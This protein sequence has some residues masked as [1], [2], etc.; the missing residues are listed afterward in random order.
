MTE[1]LSSSISVRCLRLNLPKAGRYHVI[2][3]FLSRPFTNTL[4]ALHDSDHLTADLEFLPLFNGTHLDIATSKDSLVLYACHSALEEIQLIDVPANFRTYSYGN[5]FGRIHKRY[6]P[7]GNLLRIRR[8]GN[9]ILTIIRRKTEQQSQLRAIWN[10]IVEESLAARTVRHSV[11]ERFSQQWRKCLL[12]AVATESEILAALKLRHSVDEII[13]VIL[14]GKITEIERGI[15]PGEIKVTFAQ[16]KNDVYFSLLKACDSGLLSDFEFVGLCFQHEDSGRARPNEAEHLSDPSE[17]ECEALFGSKKNV[18]AII[19]VFES[20]KTVAMIESPLRSMFCQSFAARLAL[21]PEQLDWKPGSVWFR[22]KSL[23]AILPSASA[24]IED[25]LPQ[26]DVRPH[27]RSFVDQ[28]LGVAGFTTATKLWADLRD[29]EPAD[30]AGFRVLRPLKNPGAKKV[31]LFAC[32]AA[33]GELRPH[34]FHF[35]RELRRMGYL[36]LVLAANDRSD[37]EMIDPGPETCDGLIARENIGYDF[38]LWAAALLH[39]PRLFAAEELL[40]VNDSLV[41]P[42]VPLDGFFDSIRRTKADVVGLVDSNQR[43]YHCQSFFFLLRRRAIASDAF[44]TFIKS[45]R[46]YSDKEE[47][48]KRYEL[49]FHSLMTN[50]SLSFNIQFPTT[51]FSDRNNP[52]VQYWRQLL[53]L[54][55][56][57]IKLQVVQLN[58]LMDDLSDLPEI[59]SLHAD[60]EYVESAFRSLNT[61]HTLS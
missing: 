51:K 16:D 58:P 38:A 49:E 30:V 29:G 10:E 43:N 4:V 42:L 56:P 12:V 11:P 14:D 20:D 6:F 17:Q 52:T 24:M 28:S 44:I 25:K 19:S 9:G 54:G 50:G 21:P 53:A 57:F 32:F 31:C 2:F 3:R 33:N 35:M 5:L 34:A 48:I 36:V 13:L 39:D 40:L 1:K 7:S 60:K 59:L 22:M 45:A 41:G 27:W 55:F 47:V 61:P 26:S 46:S 8:I 23:E 15:I 18:D 37:L